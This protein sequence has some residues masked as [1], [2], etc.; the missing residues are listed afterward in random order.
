MTKK[1]K[2]K[3]FGQPAINRFNLNE[4]E[5]KRACQILQKKGLSSKE[6]N[7]KIAKSENF[8]KSLNLA[9]A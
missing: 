6:L 5:S 9:H 4:T 1:E 8:F 3:Y 2:E 7:Q